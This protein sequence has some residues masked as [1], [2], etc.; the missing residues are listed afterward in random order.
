MVNKQQYV[1][2]G[3]I[4][5]LIAVW[6]SEAKDLKTPWLVYTNSLSINGLEMDTWINDRVIS[7][8]FFLPVSVD[9]HFTQGYLYW[10]SVFQDEVTRANLSNTA[11]RDNL[12]TNSR[13]KADGLAVD[14]IINPVYCHAIRFTSAISHQVFPVCCI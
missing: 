9:Y 12:V 2:P 14:M 4:L 8:L 10:T 5:V 3:V 7:S 1:F 6:S 13:S 11:D